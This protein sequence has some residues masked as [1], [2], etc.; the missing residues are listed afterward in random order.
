M[1]VV[2]TKTPKLVIERKFEKRIMVLAGI[3]EMIVGLLTIFIYAPFYRREGL[4]LIEDGMPLFEAE[5]INS[6]FSSVYMFTVSVGIFFVLLGLVNLFLSRKIKHNEVEKKMPLFLI[7]IGLA[8]YFVKDFI[9]A[10]LLL[11]AGVMMLA[12]NKSI[13][14][15]K[16]ESGEENE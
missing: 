7:V 4:D 13:I 11:T 12:K 3:W 16:F 15:N 10:V 5:A 2:R 8:S 6:V 9:G 14:K 1:E